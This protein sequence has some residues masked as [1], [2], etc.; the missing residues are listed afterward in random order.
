MFF[1]PLFL[2]SSPSFSFFDSGC[3]S[4]LFALNLKAVRREFVY[5]SM[6][7]LFR[8]V[9][10]F[11]HGRVILKIECSQ[12]IIFLMVEQFCRLLVFC[13]SVCHGQVSLPLTSV[14]AYFES[15]G[16][17]FFFF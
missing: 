14:I 4:L 13:Q 11:V 12:R 2:L 7:Q 3:Q 10:T 16:C 15:K 1:S 5:C 8:V 6:I 17:F 9:H